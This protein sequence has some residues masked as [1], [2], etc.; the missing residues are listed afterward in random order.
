ME[1]LSV[2]TPPRLE[3]DQATRRL[4]R[5]VATQCVTYERS[6]HNASRTRSAPSIAHAN[7]ARS[8]LEND[9]TLL[10]SVTGISNALF[11]KWHDTCATGRDLLVATHLLDPAEAVP[12]EE[13]DS[14]DGSNTLTDSINLRNDLQNDDS[15]DDEDLVVGTVADHPT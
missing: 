5:A 14:D 7:S 12:M 3:G 10:Q 1:R 6:F 9:L 11:A 15:S 13:G 4:I 2:F 8:A